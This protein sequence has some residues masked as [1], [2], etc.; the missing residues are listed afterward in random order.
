MIK[1]LVWQVDSF[2]VKAVTVITLG[3]RFA[4]FLKMLSEL[5]SQKWNLAI[6]LIIVPPQSTLTAM[7]SAIR[8]LLLIMISTVL[9]EHDLA[10]FLLTLYRRF[11]TFI[12]DMAFKFIHG[13]KDLTTL[14]WASKLGLIQY[15][16][17]HQVFFTFLKHWVVLTF[18]TGWTHSQSIHITCSTH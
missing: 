3:E 14:V 10:T 11:H 8:A 7:H 16:L 4:F 12:Y 18:R 17:S 13:L 9:S 5:M 15:L 2:L 6:K 1:V